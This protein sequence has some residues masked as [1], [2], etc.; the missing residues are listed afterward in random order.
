MYLK[1]ILSHQLHSPTIPLSYT[2]SFPQVIGSRKKMNVLF[3]AIKFE[4]NE[5]LSPPYCEIWKVFIFL[6]QYSYG[7]NSNS[8]SIQSLP[9]VDFYPNNIQSKQ[10]LTSLISTLCIQCLPNSVSQSLPYLTPTRLITG[11]HL[12]NIN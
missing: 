12:R 3:C 4:Y 7:S 9:T 11:S 6:L 10:L 1:G 8:N 5:I 2:K